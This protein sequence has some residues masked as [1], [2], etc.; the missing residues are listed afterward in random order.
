MM[1]RRTRLVWSIASL[2][3]IGMATA[4]SPLHAQAGAGA[5]PPAMQAPASRTL[6]TTTQVKPDM[7][8]AYQELIQNEAV[9]AYKKAGIPFRWVFTNG[10][11]GPGFTY[12]SAQPIANYAQFDQGPMLRSAMGA[13][14]FA[15]YTAKL[16]PMIVSTNG[17][18]NTLI[19][20]ASLQSFS[21]KPPAWVILTSV[22]VL[23][24]RGAEYTSIT[25]NEILPALKKAGVADSWMFA[26]NFGG[27]PAQRT[28]VTPISNWAQLDQPS[29]LSKSIGA[30][31]AQKLNQKRIVLTTNPE[32]VVLRF[33]PELSYGA[34]KRPTGTQ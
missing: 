2:V 7:V 21:E 19:P 11:V 24:G 32:T 26:T 22:E 6:V 18:I 28:I 15:K 31:A 3:V 9:P 4:G 23:P 33:V 29:P 17:V 34:P 25:T 1:N 16:R 30:E 10:P 5:Q 12:V 14:S 13:E 8:T 20:S 27:S